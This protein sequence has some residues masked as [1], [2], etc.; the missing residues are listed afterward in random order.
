MS[1][2]V[3]GG[4]FLVAAFVA[5][6]SDDSSVTP[7]T[8]DAGITA[9]TGTTPTTDS[10]TENVQDAGTDT[11]TPADTGP[12]G[13]CQTQ[14][15]P[16]GT[17]DFLCAD[18]DGPKLDQG[19]TSIK[20]FDVSDAGPPPLHFTNVV[21]MSQPQ[22]LSAFAPAATTFGARGGYLEWT[23]NGADAIKQ[24]ELTFGLNRTGPGGVVPPTTGSIMIAQV[25]IANSTASL[26][27]TAG[28]TVAD[29]NAYTGYYLQFVTS[30]GAAAL[31]N[32]K[33]PVQ[34]DDEKW[35]VVTMRYAASNAFQLLYNNVSV[36]QSS[37]YGYTGTTAQVRLGALSSGAT[38][39]ARTYRMDNVLA[40]VTR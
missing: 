35:T 32:V 19:F 34:I 21:A 10:G 5:C 14:S 31:F 12:L 18:F 39:V 36:L 15:K 17:A 7:V 40:S 4:I 38:S 26:M 16:L 1:S 23:P 24:I 22:A 9:D 27:Y 2:F 29:V 8:E 25:G 30:A 6:V 13:F 11:A 28:G 37:G 3:G 20:M 33:L